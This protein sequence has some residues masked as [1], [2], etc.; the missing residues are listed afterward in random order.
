MN[1]FFPSQIGWRA[2]STFLRPHISVKGTLHPTLS[3][4]LRAPVW[5]W[6]EEIKELFFHSPFS[7]KQNMVQF[8]NY[9]HC[10]CWSWASPVNSHNHPAG[11]AGTWYLEW[12]KNISITRIFFQ[13]KCSNTWTSPLRVLIQEQITRSNESIKRLL[14]YIYIYTREILQFP[15]AHRKMYIWD[16]MGSTC[17]TD[18]I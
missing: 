7:S 1:P 18:R 4:L 6:V 12:S 5:E 13:F 2:L 16:R 10:K 9:I 8:E 15:Y 14:L 17:N 3:I 11:L